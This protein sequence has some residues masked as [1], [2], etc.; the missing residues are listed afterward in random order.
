MLNATKCTLSL[1]SIVLTWCARHIKSRSCRLRN[2]ATT[3][4]PKVNETPRSFSPHP[5]TSLS[6]SDHRRSHS[7]PTINET[8]SPF[9]TKT[10]FFDKNF[11]N[12]THNHSANIREPPL[13]RCPFPAFYPF[14]SVLL[15]A[16]VT[17]EVVIAR[18]STLS[19]KVL[20]QEPICQD[21]RIMEPVNQFGCSAS[22]SL[23][24]STFAHSET[25]PLPG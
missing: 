7:R 11:K 9:Y 18:T 22:Y 15:A 3:S 24:L 25:L 2:F 20:R 5:C 4:G 23:G 12:Y 14:G 13:N 1:T 8:F 17:D 10:L 16:L 6:G 21:I 19:I